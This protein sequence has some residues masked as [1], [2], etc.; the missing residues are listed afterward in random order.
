MSIS[1]Q[2]EAIVNS[3]TDNNIPP[4]LV[5]IK[6]AY[7]D[8]RCDIETTNGTI[9]KRIESSGQGIPN[10]KALL[11]YEKG[12]QEKPFIILFQ[13]AETIIHSLG[14]GKFTINDGDLL[15]ELPNGID[16][17]FAFNNNGELTVTLPDN[18]TNNYSINSNGDTTYNRRSL[19]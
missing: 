15:V 6:E 11:I 13:D 17:I 4:Q 8:L 2:I 10:T 12:E 9:L 3:M 18:A 16:N 5:T 14:L 19:E 7:N 1:E